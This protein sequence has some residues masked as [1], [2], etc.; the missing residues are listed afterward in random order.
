ML[1][2]YSPYQERQWRK[3]RKAVD[4][5]ALRESIFSNIL[6]Y[7][8][9]L[10]HYYCFCAEAVNTDVSVFFNCSFFQQSE[11]PRIS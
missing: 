5:Q 2:A 10:S 6:K 9:F 7:S 11:K 8:H 4:N 1:S 3:I